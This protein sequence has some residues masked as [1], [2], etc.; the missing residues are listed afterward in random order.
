MPIEFFC[1]DEALGD[2]AQRIIFI[3]SDVEGAAVGA[4]QC[5]C[6]DEWQTFGRAVQFFYAFVLFV[7]AHPELARIGSAAADLDFKDTE[8]DLIRI[9]LGEELFYLRFR[10]GGNSNVQQNTLQRM[11]NSAFRRQTS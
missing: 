2:H 11:R 7:N 9:F 8:E 1:A 4:D 3:Y 6:H 5:G 10:F